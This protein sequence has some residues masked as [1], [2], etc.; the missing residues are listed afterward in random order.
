MKESLLR[1][2][3]EMDWITIILCCSI[4]ALVLA[5]SFFYVRFINFIILPFNNKYIFMYNKKDKLSHWFTIFL[6]IFQFLNF[7]LFI[8]LADAAFY[9]Y[10]HAKSPLFFYTILSLLVLFFIVKIL[11]HLTNAFIFNISE[12]ISEF[13]FKNITYLNYSGFIMFIANVLLTFVV[14]DSKTVVYTSAL[15]IILI[16][17]MGWAIVIRNHQKLITNNFFYFILYLCAL[18]ITPLVLIGDYFK[19]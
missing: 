14:S 2:V 9:N 4:L 6:S 17:I 12:I 18:E 7:G 1:T 10:D 13:L 11:L 15:L 19:D 3:Q 16:N 5:K 8:Y